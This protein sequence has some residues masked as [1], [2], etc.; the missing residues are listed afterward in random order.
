MYPLFKVRPLLSPNKKKQLGSLFNESNSKLF[1]MAGPD[2][3]KY[4]YPAG[5]R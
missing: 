1:E 3:V 4:S 2:L 5:E